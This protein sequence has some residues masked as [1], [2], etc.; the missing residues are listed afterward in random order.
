MTKRR[1][2]IVGADGADP[3]IIARLMGEGKLPHLAR[4]CAEGAWGALRTTFPPVSP[5]AWTTCLTGLPPAG[6]G[7]RDFITKAQD[8]YLPTIG[9]F[10]VRAGSDGIP[11]YTRRR[12][13]LTLGERLS[14]AGRTAYV[15]KV[16]GT[17]P[18]APVRGGMLAGFG[19][20]DLLGTFGV[21]A[22]YTSDEPGKKANAPEGKEL[23]HPLRPTGSG[24]WRGEIAGPA[25]TERPFILRRDGTRA[26]LSLGLDARLPAA[27][28]EAGEWSRWNRLVFDVPG[29]GAVH[30]LCRFKLVSLGQ[31]VELYRTPVQCAPDAPL[32]PLTEPP[33]FGA[34]L[35]GLIGP[36]ATL[37]MPADLD[38]VRRG[39]VDLD[40]FFQDAYANWD[41]QVEMTLRLM[42]EPSWD[43]TITHLFTVDNV[44]H[45]AWHCQDP[46][47]PSYTSRL[48]LRYGGEIERAYRWLDGQLGRLLQH[49]DSETTVIVV[50]DHG[51]LP[52]YR[53]VYLNAWLRERGY[54]FP[55]EV[56]TEGVA[57]RA[58]WGRTRAV[59]YGTGGIWLNVR[60]REPRGIVPPGAP[61]EALRREIAQALSSW[62]DPQ[63]GQQ[64][65]KQVLHGEEVFGP[66]AGEK[67][68]DLLP[69]LQ[70]GYGLGRGEGLGRAMAGTPQIVPNRSAWTGGH[71]GPYLPSDVPGI[72]VLCGPGVSGGTALGDAGLQDIAPTVL[73]I[74]GLDVAPEMAGRPLV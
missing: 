15:L 36:Y 33:G 20:P 56:S 10:D 2:L 40:T 41:R 25:G 16:P 51:G 17:F 21:S 66:E 34:R 39:V 11:A 63:T 19:M 31:V 67:G 3:Q 42:E 28:L 5:V 60:G 24:M 71:E 53:L 43:L 13:A 30:G 1:V 27:V 45:V 6:H 7:I 55:R 12:T 23:V 29:R 73:R 50:S 38:G 46:R 62:L 8:S 69:A 48:G 49:V 64:V 44:Q 9:L 61:Y 26:V 54:L 35:E 70:P 72:C 58:D 59:M 4:L 74:L 47:H 57:A 22:W 68:P 52:I 65:V 14:A 18:P 37:G 32:F